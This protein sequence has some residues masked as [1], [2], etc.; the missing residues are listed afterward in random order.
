MPSASNEDDMVF[1]VYMPPHA[2]CDGQAFFSMPM[3]SSSEM[4]P[5]AWRPTASNGDTMV[6]G[7]PFQLPGLIV[8]P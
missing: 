8:P 6:S 7:W 3:K 5:A 1:A 4:V 2:P